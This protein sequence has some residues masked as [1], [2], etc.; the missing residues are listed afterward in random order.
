M[1]QKLS[2]FWFAWKHFSGL[3]EVISPCKSELVDYSSRMTL[4][5][6]INILY[7]QSS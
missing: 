7:E 2:N 4:E 1:F 5:I 6:Y 3:G